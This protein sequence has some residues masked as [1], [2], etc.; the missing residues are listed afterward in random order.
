[1]SPLDIVMLV[2]GILLT[3]GTGVFVAS[4]F[5]LVNLDRAEVE[6]RRDRGESGLAPV[7]AALKVTS[8]H[9]SSAQLGITLTTLLTGYLLEPSIATLLEAPFLAMQLP[10][11]LVETV[12]S[13][14]ALVIA[15]L[16]SMILGELVPKN[17]ALALP[18]QTARLVV[19][20][21][22]AFT[23]V[24]KPAVA[25]LN[26]T[27]N[28]VLRSMG[29]E[30]QEELS[31]ARS[32]EELSS[33]LRR[34][35]SEGSLEQDTATLLQRTIAFSELD[36]SDVMTPRPRLSTIRVSESADDVI[37]LARRTG[38][39]RF[40]VIEEDADDVVGIVHVKQAVAVPREKRPEV[41][42]GALMTEAE[43][44]PETMPGDTL[45][46]EVRSRGY[47]MVIVVDEYG[48]TAGVV[49]LEDLVEEIVGEVS[50]EHDRA[51]IDVV[52][53]RNW[54][55]FPG[56]LRPDEL[57]DRAGVTVPED[58][59]YETVGGFIMSSLGR[60]PAVGDEVALDDGVFRVERLD[61]RRVDRVRWTPTHPDP[62]PTTGST[63]T[64]QRPA[65]GIIIP[66]TK[67]G[68]R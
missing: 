48:G 57:E 13:I 62:V 25:L 1:M 18:L 36:A 14:V 4:E 7:I 67:E 34:S 50:D 23:T 6:A 38:F 29:I 66:A 53:S 2:G 26:G 8:T 44:V 56:L 63:A 16:L 58:G 31:G 45:L 43:R 5:A 21:Q 20:L 24:F 61:G 41:P 52:R 40:P 19:P 64:A 12:G 42:V 9:L 49:T 68:S 51:R 27:A 15:T 60:L 33:L 28:A 22:V 65:T 3:L 35:A 59:P 39:S 32:A 46:A 37:A 11:A 10:E 55:T 54:L 30:P 47:Q 17:F